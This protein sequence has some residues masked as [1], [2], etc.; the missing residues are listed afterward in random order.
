VAAAMTTTTNSSDSDQLSAVEASTIVMDV[1]SA[2]QSAPSV[3][4]E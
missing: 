3:V 1:D 4:V 2:G